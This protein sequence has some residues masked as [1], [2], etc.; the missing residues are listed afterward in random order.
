M[1]WVKTAPD[2]VSLANILSS[3]SL[4]PEALRTHVSLY[5]AIIFGDSP[6]TRSEREAIAVCFSADNHCLY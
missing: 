6:L 2:T 5:R 1:T 3:H 4:H